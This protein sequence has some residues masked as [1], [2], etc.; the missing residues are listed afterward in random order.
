MSF[1]QRPGNITI[2][3]SE[4]KPTDTTSIPPVVSVNFMS[5]LVPPPSEVTIGGTITIKPGVTITDKNNKLTFKWAPMV[6]DT[7]R[8]N[9]PTIVQQ[10]GHF[11][12]IYSEPYPTQLPFT[13]TPQ[14][15]S[16]V[17]PLWSRDA[18]T[19]SAFCWGVQCN[20]FNHYNT[21]SFVP[22]LNTVDLSTT[23][24]DWYNPNP[25]SVE[26]IVSFAPCFDYEATDTV[27]QWFPVRRRRSNLIYGQG[28]LENGVYNLEKGQPVVPL[29][30]GDN[31]PD[32]FSE[33]IH[34]AYPNDTLSHVVSHTRSI[35]FIGLDSPGS[36]VMNPQWQ[37]L[38]NSPD[39]FMNL[40]TTNPGV[41]VRPTKGH[42][43]APFL[44]PGGQFCTPWF[45]VPPAKMI[46]GTRGGQV[47]NY[48]DGPTTAVN[49]TAQWDT[50]ASRTGLLNNCSGT[51]YPTMF[52]WGPL[53]EYTTWGTCD[54]PKCHSIDY[55]HAE[56]VSNNVEDNAG[57][58]GMAEGIAIR[59]RHNY[60]ARMAFLMKKHE[61]EDSY[62]EPLTFETVIELPPGRYT[63]SQL[64]YQFNLACSK[65]DATGQYPFLKTL[66]L[67]KED[68]ILTATD[69]FDDPF[70]YD[71][72]LGP[73]SVFPFS[74]EGRKGRAV[75][76]FSGNNGI[77]VVGSSEFS[78]QEGTN[79]N[80]EFTGAFDTYAPPATQTST[81]APNVP[82]VFRLNTSYQRAPWDPPLVGNYGQPNSVGG[83]AT[84]PDIQ[85]MTESIAVGPYYPQ[86]A[87]HLILQDLARISVVPSGS[88]TDGVGAPDVKSQLA[89]QVYTAK[90]SWTWTQKCDNNAAPEMLN[91][92]S[93]RN[94]GNEIA[95]SVAGNIYC[96]PCGSTGIPGPHGM[97]VM[98]IGDGSEGQN[99]L[100]RSLGFDPLQLAS[101]WHPEVQ[102]YQVL[103]G[104]AYLPGDMAPTFNKDYLPVSNLSPDLYARWSPAAFQA[105]IR[106]SPTQ[107][108][109]ASLL[110]TLT[111][112]RALSFGTNAVNATP[113]VEAVSGS[114]MRQINFSH[115]M[116]LNTYDNPV[117]SCT[118]TDAAISTVTV[119]AAVGDSMKPPIS[120]GS[121]NYEL[122][123]NGFTAD[124]ALFA[125]QNGWPVQAAVVSP[126]K[127]DINVSTAW[128]STSTQPGNWH[129][130]AYP[131]STMVGMNIYNVHSAQ[132]CPLEDGWVPFAIDTP[133]TFQPY[134]QYTWASPSDGSSTDNTRYYPQWLPGSITRSPPWFNQNLAI[135]TINTCCD[136]F[137]YNHG[138]QSQLVYTQ[139][140][141]AELLSNATCAVPNFEAMPTLT[142]G[143]MPPLRFTHHSLWDVYIQGHTD[144]YFNGNQRNGPPASTD[145]NW[146]NRSWLCGQAATGGN[147]YNLARVFATS[148]NGTAYNVTPSQACTLIK[149]RV[150]VA[151][152]SFMGSLGLVYCNQQ[153][154]A[155]DNGLFGIVTRADIEA[156]TVPADH[157]LKT[158]LSKLGREPSRFAVVTNWSPSLPVALCYPSGPNSALFNDP[159]TG[160]LTVTSG[161]N[162]IQQYPFSPT[163]NVDE[164]E[165]TQIQN[166]S[167]KVLQAGSIPASL[168]AIQQTGLMFVRVEGFSFDLPSEVYINGQRYT[169]MIPLQV[170][171]D[172]N[173]E[174]NI[175]SFN[176]DQTWTMA[177][178]YISFLQFS[179]YDSDANPL[180][181]VTN[182]RLQVILSAT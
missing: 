41:D 93:N 119:G 88:K 22:D 159:S 97:Q 125:L 110:S 35:F 107:G 61:T 153:V 163:S 46:Y 82:S 50:Q 81:L 178:Q 155:H 23:A 32:H 69:Y 180:T 78:L 103:E 62:C 113:V 136:F 12:P 45:P 84:T 104:F 67:R 33:L 21:I 171:P 138:Y 34:I 14:Y 73:N 173:N 121:W 131:W 38:N 116:F 132:P 172:S 130:A 111:P 8:A 29:T 52:S 141:F 96:Q 3:K 149:G 16:T 114:V 124:P 54:F 175:L 108:S 139:A 19:Q 164:S 65:V 1:I 40:T 109:F 26:N 4:G 151:G 160:A 181:G 148:D 142:T 48:T 31:T 177:S 168:S 37:V 127:V 137:Y 156:E 42:F 7:P 170:D 43:Y 83:A 76:A 64:A 100:L 86:E 118:G 75:H 158:Q 101:L 10:R 20:N 47:R 123:S 17:L 30:S 169:E 115:P 145:A 157:I 117:S 24:T 135:H 120:L 140:R 5:P 58:N 126:V 15:P 77:Q 161:T 89:G 79:G 85:F 106:Q 87:N 92:V 36:T 70:D 167:S 6:A 162:F 63:P 90:S 102:H 122:I 60:T 129:G 99:N 56:V 146:A 25:L 55:G 11:P 174:L 44:I 2:L 128:N 71:D 105:T 176:S 18:T 59:P 13:P 27:H 39:S 53:E 74:T 57:L 66:D 147:Q 91:P 9:I 179:F 165:P 49:V 112:T 166:P 72:T 95:D 98:S 68:L 182:I 133:S 150:P 154:N 143:V 94:P 28:W 144:L 134:C 152:V 51:R 80:L